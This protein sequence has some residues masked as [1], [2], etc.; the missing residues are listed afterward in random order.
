MA[1]YQVRWKAPPLG[2]TDPTPWPEIAHSC[3]AA[4]DTPADPMD[5]SF[6]DPS[7]RVTELVQQFGGN[8]LLLSICDAEF[9]PAL[10]V[11][12]EKIEVAIQPP[13]I[14]GQIANRPGTSVPDCTVVNHTKT[15]GRV[16]D[17]AVRSCAE[18]GGATPCWQLVP[19]QG[20][21]HCADDADQ[22][23]SERP[24]G[25]Q[26]GRHRRLR[27]VRPGR[28]RARTR[29]SVADEAN[30][31]RGFRQ[32]GWRN[33]PPNPRVFAGKAWPAG[34]SLSMNVT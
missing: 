27:A 13:C 24:A 4:D 17:A 16:V 19:G 3:T 12:A 11:I 2:V 23:R 26:S 5:D 34:C 20:I 31:G 33:L 10:R 14:E 28:E 22:Q 9:E 15:N 30:L 21:L 7:V 25:H 18:S 8:G 29:L 6:A 32:R 1:P